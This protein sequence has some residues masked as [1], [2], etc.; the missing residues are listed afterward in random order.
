MKLVCAGLVA[1]AGCI[2]QPVPP[3]TAPV[4]APGGPPPGG[5]AAYGGAAYGGAAYGGTAAQPTGAYGG[6]TYGSANPGGRIPAAEIVGHWTGDWGDLYLTV[7]R[8]GTVRGV[9][10]HDTGTI[11]GR[12]RGDVLYGWWCEAPSRQPSRDAGVVE[13]RFG[14]DASGLYV[15]GRWRYGADGGWHEDWDLR[16]VRTPV[17]QGLLRRLDDPSQFCRGP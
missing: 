1:L 14:R 2:V 7:D 11:T 17:D 4:T 8:D 13:L 16:W 12:M 10:P 5:G 9:Y 3:P 6:A 15:D